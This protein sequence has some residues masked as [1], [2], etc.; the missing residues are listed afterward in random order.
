MKLIHH[1]A[2]Y[3]HAYT[4]ICF[5]QVS[6]RSGKS[7]QHFRYWPAVSRVSRVVPFRI[8]DL[9]PAVLKVSIDDFPCTVEENTD[10]IVM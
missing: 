9:K 7:F 2:T 6:G 1:Q 8:A 4:G 10:S 3:K 5:L